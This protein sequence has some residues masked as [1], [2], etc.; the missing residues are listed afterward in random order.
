MTQAESIISRFG[1]PRD[2]A[3]AI[4]AAPSTVYKWTYPL[5]VNEGTGGMIPSRQHRAIHAA[6]RREG[7][8]LTANDWYPDN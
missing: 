6:A 2:L 8:L 1:G 4:G 5:G 7:I 3:R